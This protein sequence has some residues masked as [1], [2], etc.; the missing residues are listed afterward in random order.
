M[1]LKTGVTIT[2]WS[3]IL[4]IAIV[5]T[6]IIA[7]YLVRR[8]KSVPAIPRHTKLIIY[9]MEKFVEGRVTG[10]VKDIKPHPSGR[11]L[12]DY[13]AE[14]YTDEELNE[15]EEIPLQTIATKNLYVVP[16]GRHSKAFNIAMVLPKHYTETFGN[17][18]ELPAEFR[19]GFVKA[20]ITEQIKDSFWDG[21]LEGDEGLA[22][23]LKEISKGEISRE[24]FQKFKGIQNE[25]LK[26]KLGLAEPKT[27]E[28]KT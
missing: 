23:L 3:I 27:E 26:E 16:R 5:V 20:Q 24:A 15:M 21:V 2:I 6:I 19:K 13:Y 12:I 25:N 10:F 8:I 28:K 7:T 4:I 18:E 14:D 1:V 17:I 9:G 11:Y 22:H